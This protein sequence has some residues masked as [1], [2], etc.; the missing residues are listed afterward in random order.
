MVGSGNAPPNGPPNGPQNGPPGG[1][2]GGTNGG[3]DVR[4]GETG[5]FRWSAGLRIDTPVLD[6]PITID[7]GWPIVFTVSR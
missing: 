6:V 7:C 2:A 3:G 4:D 1:G 5:V